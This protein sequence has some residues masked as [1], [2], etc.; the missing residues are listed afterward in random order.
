LEP[1]FAGRALGLKRDS[2]YEQRQAKNGRPAFVDGLQEVHAY[3]F[4]ER[5]IC[6]VVS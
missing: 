6:S 2:G 5:I 3:T 4:P 1:D